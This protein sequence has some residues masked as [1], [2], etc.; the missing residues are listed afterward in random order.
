M[1]TAFKKVF[2]SVAQH[3]NVDIESVRFEFRGSAITGDQTPSEIG[4]NDGDEIDCLYQ[5]YKKGTAV[6]FGKS[7]PEDRMI[8]STVLLRKLFKRNLAHGLK[9]FDLPEGEFL[10]ALN[11]DSAQLSGR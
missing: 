7:I 8:Q 6:T 11:E 10:S 1:D 5:K 9:S 2:L 4:M 3:L